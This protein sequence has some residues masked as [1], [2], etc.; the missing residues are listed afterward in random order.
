MK[1]AL[2]A[3]DYVQ[4]FPLENYGGIETCVENL[5]QG[6]FDN[7]IDFFVVCPKRKNKK[8]YPFEV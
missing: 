5:A 8:E 4:Q 3:N 6:L 1:I 7:K 2:I